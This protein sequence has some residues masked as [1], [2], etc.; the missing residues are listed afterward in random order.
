[1]SQRLRITEMAGIRPSE[2]H[3]LDES[4]QAVWPLNV[5]LCVLGAAILGMAFI[6]LDYRDTRVLY[7]PW[8]YAIATPLVLLGLSALLSTVVS[9]VVEKSMQMAFLLSVLMHLIL[10]VCASNV[11]IFS[12]MWPDVLDSLAQQREQLKRESLQAKQYH[13]I[14]STTQTGRRPD[15]LKPVETEHQPTELKTELSPSLALS[16]SQRTNLVSPAPKV[17]LTHSPHL[18]QRDKPATTLP[19]PSQQAASVSR[20]DLQTPPA[21]DLAV[22]IPLSQQLDPQTLPELAP[23]S[24]SLSRNSERQASE[25]ARSPDLLQ[26]A[27]LSG[28]TSSQASL[29]R[30]TAL[31]ASPTTQSPTTQSPDRFSRERAEIATL[32]PNAS[33]AR[34]IQTPE[35]GLANLK[36]VPLESNPSASAG[37]RNNTVAT[38]PANLSA[39]ILSANIAERNPAMRSSRELQRREIQPPSAK[40]AADPAAR[41]LPRDSSGGSLGAAAP[42]SMPIQGIEAVGA[43]SPSQ[44]IE[45]KVA[46]AAEAKRQSGARRGAT[47]LP[48]LGLPQGPSWN[49]DLLQSAGTNGLSPSQ[50]AKNAADGQAVLPD[51]RSLT[52]ASSAQATLELSRSAVAGA[53]STP[54]TAPPSGLFAEDASTGA[55]PQVSATDTAIGRTGN[56]EGTSS[57]PSR[58]LLARQLP[59]QLLNLRIPSELARSES[60][61]TSSGQGVLA[62]KPTESSLGRANPLDVAVRNNS[63]RSVPTMDTLVEEPSV[64]DSASL[65]STASASA[66]LAR[67]TVGANS[68]P[69]TMNLLDV[70]QVEGPGGIEASVG[71]VGPLLTRRDATSLQWAPPQIESQRFARQDVGGKLAAGQDVALPKPAFQQRLDRLQDHNPQDESSL[72]PQTEL[73]IE[74][75]LAFLA[76]NQRPDGSWRLQDLDT[77][78]LMRSDTAATAL[79]L[80]AFQGA[81]YTHNQFKY[82]SVVDKAV[83]FLVKHQ[84]DNGDL[85]IPQDP[86]SDQNAWLYSHAIAT[87]ALSE[88]YGMTQDVELRPAAQKAIDFMVS[89]QDPRRGGWR[90]RPG[91]GSDTSVTGWFMMAFKSGQLAG[92]TVPRK[93]FELLESFLENSQLSDEEP[94]LYRYN[95]FAANTPQQR[96]GLEPTSVMTSVGLLM[97]LYFGWQRDREE[98]MAGADHL[99]EHPPEN[100]S[101]VSSRR[102]TYYWYYATQVMFHMRGERWKSWHDRLY[103]LLINSQI[104]QGDMEGSWDPAYPTP[105]LWA[106]YGGRLYVTTLNLL[107]LEVSY[108]HLPL[109][110][111]TA[112]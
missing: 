72:E 79:S 80:L 5:M 13:R 25:L 59:N 75:G 52:G 69:A 50:L 85:Y 53:L 76:K 35:A 17:E 42:S 96:H 57:L 109:Y 11:V 58:D 29:Q 36:A 84:A 28:N 112:Q 101:L 81:G 34:S 106:R 9:Q 1:M 46:S 4:S 10:L 12:R 3:W 71:Q 49:G 63:I 55:D 78:V 95:P 27:S 88:A 6:F 62:A 74:R 16:R 19:K 40:Q 100:G 77:P 97:R 104:T 31:A 18:L 111:A 61:S 99:L 15:Y 48:E 98:M 110:E 32:S 82:A 105:D 68:V 66:Q 14:A 2:D 60:S 30:A 90:Y 24:S 107:S 92:L 23:S 37:R 86:A 7:S 70:Q 38:L 54:A 44:V 21:P 51:M 26:S 83:Q 94:H 73:A 45:L 41:T 43:P 108:R 67:S 103:P 22:R 93:S 56:S 91:V 65:D 33:V 87:L 47:S 39:N 20:S 89:S 64:S 8:T 102:D